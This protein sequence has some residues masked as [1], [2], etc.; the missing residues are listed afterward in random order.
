MCGLAGIVSSNTRLVAEAPLTAAIGCLQHRGP[1]GGR[2]WQGPS[3]RCAL[4]HNRLSIIDPDPRSLQPFHYGKGYTLVYNGELY[5]YVELRDELRALGH[6]FSTGSDTE[7]LLA[8]WAAWGAGCVQRFDGMFAFALWDEGRQQLFASRDRFGEKPFFFAFD[9][10]ALRFASELKA[11]WTLGVPKT[12]NSAMA[13]NFLTLGYTG[14]PRDGKETFYQDVWK[15]PAGHCLHFAPGDEGALVER[16]SEADTVEIQVD[17]NRAVQEFRSLLSASVTRRLRSDVPVGTSL[18]GGIDSAAVAALCTQAGGTYTH[19]A[20]TAIFPGFEKDEEERSRLVAQHLGLQQEF[21]RIHEGEVPALMDRVMHHQEEPIG[22]GSALAQ[23]KVYEAA[24]RSGVTVL[25]D[26]QGA[27]EILAGYNKYYR[28]YWQELYR[29]RRLGASGELEAARR[30][31]VTE[32]FESIHRVAALFPD[33]ASSLLEGRKGK[34]AARTPGLHPEW[35]ARYRGESYYTVP[36][37]FT[38]NGALSYNT[39]QYGLEELLRTADRNSMAHSVEVRLPF[40]SH[41]LVEYLFR[42]PPQFK[43]RGGW[44]KWLLRESVRDLLPAPIAWQAGKT[45]F[46]PPQAQWM[47]TSAVQEAIRAGMEKLVAHG[48]LD[49]PVLQ[50]KIQPHSAYAAVSQHWR[51]WSLSYLY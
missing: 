35:A 22:S 29:A 16:Y 41:E 40:L 7:V 17:D 19:K 9:G 4:A 10:E 36:A 21:V 18:S 31:G 13:F 45:G 42:L 12:V 48:V 20:F 14:N 49:G 39:F 28:W 51:Y 50:K 30:N 25:L 32:P 15:L 5:N 11:L 1:E 37:Q 44:T 46:E 6:A 8:A 43:I 34:A 24:K 47:E 27:D 38:L 23:F 2:G 26:G 33:L 3:G